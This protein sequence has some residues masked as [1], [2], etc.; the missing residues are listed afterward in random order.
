VSFL[1]SC[2]GTIYIHTV[3]VLFSVPCLNKPIRSIALRQRK[4]QSR[5]DI[6]VIEKSFAFFICYTGSDGLR[7]FR[8]AMEKI[9]KGQKRF[10]CNRKCLL[11]ACLL[12]RWHLF[13]NDGLYLLYQLLD[14]IIHQRE[15]LNFITE[16]Y[17]LYKHG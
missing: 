6:G 10:W 4:V 1:H 17:A 3:Y 9:N 7:G 13:V 14:S 15:L 8:N 2:L 16:C 12:S 5:I 11:I